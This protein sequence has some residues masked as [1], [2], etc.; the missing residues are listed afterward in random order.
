MPNNVY[1]NPLEFLPFLRLP[2]PEEGL[3]LVILE[4]GQT[5]RV[6]SF[7]QRDAARGRVG[8][9]GAV[10]VNDNPTVNLQKGAIVAS[11]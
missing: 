10:I 9:M 5:E 2:R 11:Q 7:H 1:R 8:G 4:I 6:H 3:S